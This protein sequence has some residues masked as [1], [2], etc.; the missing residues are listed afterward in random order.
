M[1]DEVSENSKVDR[2]AEIDRAAEDIKA[3]GRRIGRLSIAE[4]LAARH[5]GHKY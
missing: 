2:Q 4:L 1:A 5:E 3:L